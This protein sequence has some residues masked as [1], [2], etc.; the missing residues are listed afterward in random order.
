MPFLKAWLRGM[1]VRMRP[2]PPRLRLDQKSYE[3][4]R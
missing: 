3:K 1:M 2:E 4:L